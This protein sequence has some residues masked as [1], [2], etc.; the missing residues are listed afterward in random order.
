MSPLAE[1][2]AT[3]G[4]GR[5]NVDQSPDWSVNRSAFHYVTYS[6]FYL[7]NFLRCSDRLGQLL[8]LVD[9]RFHGEH[10]SSADLY[11]VGA[12]A[13]GVEALLGD[14]PCQHSGGGG[15]VTCLFVCVISHILH[16]LGP[17][18]LVLVFKVDAFGNRD[19]VF[20]DLRAAPALLDD[21]RASLMND[22]DVKIFFFFSPKR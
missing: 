9:D 15:A 14:G 6:N 5:R 11:G 17:D 22:K 18:V 20:G 2:V 10:D 16:Q 1:I 21:D 19:S 13:D 7:S 12:F 3:C 4:P 8:E